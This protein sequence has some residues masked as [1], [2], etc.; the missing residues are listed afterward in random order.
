MLAMFIIIDIY[1]LHY[2]IMKRHICQCVC[3]ENARAY[4]M[5]SDLCNAPASA[6]PPPRLGELPGFESRYRS[7]SGGSVRCAFYAHPGTPRLGFLPFGL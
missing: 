7:L 5:G 2:D 3:P 6:E 4:E 1:S